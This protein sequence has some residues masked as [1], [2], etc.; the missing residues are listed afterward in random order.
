MFVVMC[1]VAVSIA[2]P[3]NENI[4]LIEI[5]PEEQNNAPLEVSDDLEVA[6]SAQYGHGMLFCPF[7]LRMS[8]IMFLF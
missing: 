6:E 8:Q 1:L 7:G 2:Y 5:Q 3:A 4:A